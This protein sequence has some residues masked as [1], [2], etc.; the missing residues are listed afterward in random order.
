MH[1]GEL[2]A[3]FRKQMQWTHA[4]LANAMNA[5]A[6]VSALSWIQDEYCDMDASNIEEIEQ[7]ATGNVFDEDHVLFMELFRNCPDFDQCEFDLAYAK[8]SENADVEAELQ[9]ALSTEASKKMQ[10]LQWVESHFALEDAKAIL[11][12]HLLLHS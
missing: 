6:K 8:L 2:I 7:D 11:E 4:E 12:D 10:F 5:A 9:L 1:Y 3:K